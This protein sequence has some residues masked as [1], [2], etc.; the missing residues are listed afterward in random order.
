MEKGNQLKRT[1]TKGKTVVS[2]IQAMTPDDTSMI[3]IFS[4]SESTVGKAAENVNSKVEAISVKGAPAF[5]E[6]TND[7]LIA[8]TK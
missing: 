2:S 1:L 6:M 5:K 8:F 4:H 7:S 3:N